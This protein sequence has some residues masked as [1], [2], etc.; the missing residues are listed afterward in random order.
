VAFACVSER[1]KVS[2][3]AI[4]LPVLVVAACAD[5]SKGSA[6]LECR[7]RYYLDDPAAQGQLVPE[8][9][10]A[11]SFEAAPACN[12]A[13]GAPQW[14]WQA[15]SPPFDDPRC[16]R[17]VGAVPWIATVLSPMS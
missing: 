14:D 4:L 8:C 11:K 6:L 13:A 2:R 12:P 3:F 16:Y 10:Q 17:P 7:M 15:Q 1:G 9:M 5:A